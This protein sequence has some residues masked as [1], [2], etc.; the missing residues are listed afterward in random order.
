MITIFNTI[1]ICSQV[2]MNDYNPEEERA[3][4]QARYEDDDDEGGHGHGP[5]VNCATQ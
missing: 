1:S 5:G 3:R 2:D 4:R